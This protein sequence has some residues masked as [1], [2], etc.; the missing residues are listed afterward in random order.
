MSAISAIMSCVFFPLSVRK[1]NWIARSHIV[2]PFLQVFTSFM[3]MFYQYWGL[4]CILSDYLR[5]R[6]QVI[7]F[8]MRIPLWNVFRQTSKNLNST[9]TK[10]PSCTNPMWGK[11]NN[12]RMFNFWTKLLALFTHIP[13]SHLLPWLTSTRKH[14]LVLLLRH[15]WQLLL[16]YINY[17]SAFVPGILSTLRNAFSRVSQEFS[18]YVICFPFPWEKQNK[19]I[20][21]KCS[22]L[23]SHSL[24]NSS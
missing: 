5:N 7:E 9:I 19:L 15:Y 11:F 13:S 23:F 16:C 12:R 1:S 24:E 4:L 17:M 3:Y 20:L 2:I 6:N 8:R 18:Q 10:I 22:T 14:L 21:E